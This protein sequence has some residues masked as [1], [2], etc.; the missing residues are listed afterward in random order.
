MAEPQSAMQDVV[1]VT[2]E[3]QEELRELRSHC[4][5]Q[6]EECRKHSNP[7]P[8][9]DAFDMVADRLGVILDGEK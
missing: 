2:I 4:I 1:D 6:A 5:F 8:A 7:M 3:L 9:S